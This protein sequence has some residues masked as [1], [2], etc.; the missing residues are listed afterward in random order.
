MSESRGFSAKPVDAKDFHARYPTPVVMQFQPEQFSVMETKEDLKR[1]ESDLARRV[2]M[3]PTLARRFVEAVETNGG[4]CCESGD[5]NDC[6]A[7]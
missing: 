1:W 4:T 3:S 6:D 2:G 5:T 7:D